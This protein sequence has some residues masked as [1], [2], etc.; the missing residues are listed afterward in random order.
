MI[1]MHRTASK[2]VLT[3]IFIVFH[4]FHHPYYTSEINF[5]Q[6]FIQLSSSSSSNYHPNSTV[7]Y[8]SSD[9]LR[10]HHHYNQHH[11]HRRQQS[12]SSTVGDVRRYMDIVYA[13]DLADTQLHY[14]VRSINSI[15]QTASNETY[16][17][18]RIHVFYDGKAAGSLYDMKDVKKKIFEGN[19]ILIPFHQLYIHSFEGLPLPTTIKVWGT[20][21]YKLQKSSNFVRF[22]APA[23]LHHHHQSTRLLYLDT[24]TY[25]V[26]DISSLYFT[27]V[28]V[29]NTSFAAGKQKLKN[30]N[31]GKI[32]HL[33]HERIHPLGIDPSADCITASVLLIDVDRWRSNQLTSKVEHWMDINKVPILSFLPSFLLYLLAFII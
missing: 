22:Y 12:T 13:T 15:T 4:Y 29:N 16:I 24:D 27:T 33:E 11:H 7:S 8:A 30:C 6:A 19:N 14:L 21:S 28:M 17:G 3:M 18:L 5:T 25:A 31:F 9:E 32:V 2:L 26:D 23:Y 10:D 1:V 20:Y